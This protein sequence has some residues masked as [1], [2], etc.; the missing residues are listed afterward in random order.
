MQKTIGEVYRIKSL[1][2][3][4]FNSVLSPDPSEAEELRT[5]LK[6]SLEYVKGMVNEIERARG[7]GVVS[8]E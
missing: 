8:D 4:L 5:K 2:E 1:V 7:Q 3:A 6:Q